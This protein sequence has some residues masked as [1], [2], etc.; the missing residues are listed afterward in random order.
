MSN[1]HEETKDERITPH[2]KAVMEE[3]E[4]YYTKAKELRE[5]KWKMDDEDVCRNSLSSRCT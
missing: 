1:H 3:A 4:E 2:E 5:S